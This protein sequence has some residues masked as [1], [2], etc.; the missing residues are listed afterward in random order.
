MAIFTAI[1]AA[2]TAVS[3]WIGGLS[4]LSAFALKTAVG[5]GLSLASQA[6]AG[7]PKQ[8]EQKFSINGGLQ[9]GGALARSFILGRAATAGSLVWAN[10]WGRD[11]G[12]P[13]AWLT[14]VIALSDLPVKGLLEV[15]VDGIRVDY[16]LSKNNDTQYGQAIPQFN[17][18]GPNLYIKFYDGTQTAADPTLVQTDSTNDRLWNNDRIGRGVAYV[19]VRARSTKGVFSGI[20]SLRFVVDGLRLYDP[21]RDSTNGGVGPQRRADKSTWGGDGDD[22]PVVQIYNLMLGLD[23]ETQWVYG[24]QNMAMARLPSENWVAQINKCR[25]TILESGVEQPTYRCGGEINVDAPLSVAMDEI[26]TSCQGKVSEAGGIYTVYVG[27][28]DAPLFSIVDGDIVS[29]EEQDFTPFYGLADS[30]NGISATYPEPLDGYVERTA[31]PLLRPD[32]EALDGNRRLLANVQFTFV[33]YAEQVQRL[34][35]S[36]L[37]SALRYRKHTI[38]LPPKFW[39]YAVPGET[40]RWTSVRN[41]YVNKLFVIDGVSDK[42]NLDVTVSISEWD[43]SDYS[44]NS[45]A[46]FQ[47]PVAGA[48]GPVLPSARPLVDPF[49]EPYEYRDAMNRNRRPAIRLVWDSNQETLIGV[50]GV[51]WEVRV[52]ENQEVVLTGSTLF[53]ERGSVILSSGILTN[54]VY[55]VRMRY[56][57]LDGETDGIWT[58]WLSVLSPNIKIGGLDIEVELAS[59]GEDAQSV[60]RALNNQIDDLWKRLEHASQAFS[61][62]GAVGEVRANKLSAQ[63]GRNSAS[64]SE[65]RRVRVRDNEALAQTITTVQAN[66]E[67]NSAAIVQEATARATEDQ[68]LAEL[69]TGVRADIDGNFADGLVSFQAVAAPDGVNVRFAILVRASLNDE[70][71]ESGMFIEIYTEGGTLRSRIVNVA[72][73]FLV[74]NGSDIAEPIFAVIDGVVTIINARIDAANIRNLVVDESNIVPGAVTNYQIY[75]N[76]DPI[77]A[78]TSLTT[79]ASV[80]VPHGQ[81]SPDIEILFGYNTAT[82]QGVEPRTIRQRLVVVE[83]G[84]TIFDVTGPSSFSSSA[85][86]AYPLLRV[87]FHRPPA[88]RESSTYRI[89]ISSGANTIVQ[90]RMR[91][92]RTLTLKR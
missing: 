65:E 35:K 75:S 29:T 14:Q 85:S 7:K 33:P 34:M 11:S 77:N 73:Q 72:N 78:G 55:E 13:N 38:T 9:G 31:P 81:G 15:W 71:L 84:E 2:V 41:G 59:L 80:T 42:A 63:L 20:P 56:V 50:S 28:P 79:I 1:T 27:E 54:V 23:Y 17:K 18:D 58:S 43:P 44:W 47:P 91:T 4:A 10:T 83:T 66:V 19:I 70:Y 92:L 90:A 45:S 52:S 76:E 88:D 67:D 36:A 49:V 68:A 46:E 30:I 8:Q 6:L 21:S 25:A 3:G 64:I 51:Q 57:P 62:E 89:E 37:L 82:I 74:S 87:L 32:L 12:A 24:F 39:R 53:P 5:I 16:D 40:L 22:L 60:W 61:L 26:L 48:L 86:G 69:I